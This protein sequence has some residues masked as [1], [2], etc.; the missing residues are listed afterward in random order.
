MARSAEAGSHFL[1]PFPPAIHTRPVDGGT[2]QL[3][4][5]EIPLGR[6]VRFSTKNKLTPQTCLCSGC[7]RLT[8]MVGLSRAGRDQRI[9]STIDSISEKEFQLARFIAAQAKAGL[10][11]ALDPDGRTTQVGR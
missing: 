2:K 3:I 9:T 1:H 8:A 6:I 4:E 7:G 10:I 11:V 5:K